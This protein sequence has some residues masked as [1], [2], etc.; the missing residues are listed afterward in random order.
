MSG[1][2]RMVG[3]ALSPENIL[4][5]NED[6]F[7]YI[8]LSKKYKRMDAIKAEQAERDKQALNENSNL[9]EKFE[10]Y[11]DNKDD[12]DEFLNTGF[13]NNRSN[14]KNAQVDDIG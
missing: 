13:S 7:F 6:R 9:D 12:I 10:F 4:I 11:F 2:R 5:L 1:K 14:L 3:G 8:D